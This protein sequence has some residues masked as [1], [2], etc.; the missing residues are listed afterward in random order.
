[1]VGTQSTGE[2]LTLLKE[3]VT[4]GKEI[5]TAFES[6]I[7]RDFKGC[8]PYD[9]SDEDLDDYFVYHFVHNKMTVAS[10]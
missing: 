8:E 1:M 9:I 6:K 3:V 2:R 5:E 10:N 4:L 7:Q